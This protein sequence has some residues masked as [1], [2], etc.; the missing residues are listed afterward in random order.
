MSEIELT[1]GESFKTESAEIYGEW[2]VAQ[3]RDTSEWRWIPTARVKE[4]TTDKYSNAV[5][6]VN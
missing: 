3:V 2:V 5:E 6:F 1:D 4:V